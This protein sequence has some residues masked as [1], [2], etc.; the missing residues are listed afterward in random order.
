MILKTIIISIL[1]LVIGFNPAAIK[2]ST[3]IHPVAIVKGETSGKSFTKWYSQGSAFFITDDGYLGTAAHVVKDTKNTTIWY[4]G[5]FIPAKVVMVD[6]DADTAILKADLKKKNAYF[7]ISKPKHGEVD[8]ILG[9]PSVSNFG[10]YLHATTGISQLGIGYISIYAMSC[11]GNSGGAVVNSNGD[12]VGIL[13]L[14]FA[15]G[16]TPDGLCSSH[17]GAVYLDRLISMATQLNLNINKTFDKK[18][19]KLQSQSDMISNINNE[20]KVVFVQSEILDK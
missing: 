14:G 10:F 5:K 8:T 20:Q 7:N 1:A 17:A 2:T 6:E 13:T 3:S 12:L 18:E 4:D 16:F 15:D 19:V 9:F 11:H